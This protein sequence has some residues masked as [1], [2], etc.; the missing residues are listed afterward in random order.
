MP[1]L[2]DRIRVL[3]QYRVDV[4]TGTM[5]AGLGAN[6]PIFSF[7]WGSTTKSALIRRVSI[8]MMSLGTGFAVGSALFAMWVARAFSGSDSAGNAVTLTTNNGKKRTQFDTS[9]VTDMRMSSTATLTAGTRT[10]DTN[11]F[12]AIMCGITASINTVFQPTAEIFK[13]DPSAGEM[14][15]A[16]VSNEGF[17]IAATVPATG[18]WQ[19]R[20]Q[21][22]WEE[23]DALLPLPA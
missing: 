17:I 4:V 3:G 19:A 22:D 9:L 10:L 20:V 23:L 21:V 7:R 15:L 2:F 12:A 13:A 14:P 1:N 8:S 11:A 5:A 16:L 6:A 18:T